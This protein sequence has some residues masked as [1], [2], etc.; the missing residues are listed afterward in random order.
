CGLDSPVVRAV[1]E[2]AV[3]MVDGFRCKVLHK[4]ASLAV[5][6]DEANAGMFD[7]DER[8]GIDDCIPWTRVVEERK[9]THGGKTVDLIP[10][11]VAHR[12]R[13]V[14]KPNDEYGGKGIVLGWTVDDAT[15]ELAVQEAMKTPHIVQD[16]VVIPSESYPSWV[17]GRVETYDRMYDTAPFVTNE[18]YMEGLL[19]R[20]ST[21]D[22]LNVTAG[23]GS[24]VPTF[25]AERR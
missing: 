20:L 11:I 1:R 5:L 4:K 7:D 25:I 24:T 13:F 9:T 2:G 23:G 6:S 17:N 22:L 15:W 16:K 12:E 8:G 10:H 18:E 19:T 21:V 3:C 14:V